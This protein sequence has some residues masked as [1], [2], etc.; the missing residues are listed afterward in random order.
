VGSDE[1]FLINVTGRDRPG[2]VAMVMR[3]L[4]AYGV[5]VLDI[6]QAVIHEFIALGILIEI[7]GAHAWPDVMKDLLLLAHD[8]EIQ[9]RFSPIPSEQYERWVSEQGKERRIITVMGRRLTADQ[10]GA[11]ASVCAAH[12][13]NIDVITR[14]SGRVSLAKPAASPRACVEFSVSGSLPSE[15]E[16]RAQLLDL[17]QGHAIDVAFHRDDIYRRNR[18]LVVFDMDSTLIRI[19]VIDELARIAGVGEEVRAITDAAMRGELDFSASLRQR[20]RLL[21]GLDAATLADVAESLPLTEGAARVA[22]TLKRLGYK[23]G[24]ISGGFSIFGDVLKERLG[25]DYVFAN[26]LEIADGRL[27]GNVIGEI[28]DGPRK[29]GILQELAMRE[30]LSLDQTI[31]VGDGAN[32]IPMLSAAGMGVAF[33]AKPIV[34]EKAGRAISTV[35]LDG[36]L[37]LMGIREREVPREPGDAREVGDA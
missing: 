32:D 21:R 1:V 16:I 36:L 28:I 29:A 10:I 15:Q 12:G 25:F 6:G 23:V 7:P 11:V 8:L 2:L 17:A 20:V 14:L 5:K 31:A 37:F 13:L 24:I 33:H 18:R 3:G 9:I 22:Q 4:A 34:R 35:G 30:G 26:Q 19:E 27:T